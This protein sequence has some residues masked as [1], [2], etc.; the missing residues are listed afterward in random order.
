MSSAADELVGVGMLFFASFSIAASVSMVKIVYF[1]MNVFS[2]ILWQAIFQAVM[3]YIGCI[4]LQVNPFKSCVLKQI[5]AGFLGA[6]TFVLGFW[7]AVNMELSEGTIIKFSAP[8]FTLVLARYYLKEQISWFKKIGMVLGLIGVVLAAK[9]QFIFGDTPTLG[10]NY[11]NRT[12]AIL[13][14]ILSSL[15]M[16]GSTII[17]KEIAHDVHF[18]APMFYLT[19]WYI[20]IAIPLKLTEN[21]YVE[22]DGLLI[23]FFL[24]IGFFLGQVFGFLGISKVPAT[25]VT[26]IKNLDSFFGVIFGIL[27]FK[28]TIEWNTI[29]GCAMIF[30]VTLVL[31]IENYYLSKRL[32]KLVINESNMTVQAQ[33][34]GE[35]DIFD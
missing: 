2:I 32:E 19:T 28:E 21:F 34:L 27:I 18:F 22:V 6:A 14:I 13:A 11:P 5:L 4:L 25:V 17:I 31:V 26:L 29:L 15:C 8:L 30:C 16:A 1:T 9:P 23:I 24:T 35:D 12:W 20:L 33:E 7:G 10:Q 3:V